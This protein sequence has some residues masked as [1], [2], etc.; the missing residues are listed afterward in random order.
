MTAEMKV[1]NLSYNSILQSFVE[2][3]NMKSIKKLQM[4][5]SPTTLVRGGAGVGQFPTFGSLNLAGFVS[6][7]SELIPLTYE[8][9][10]LLYL[11]N[12]T[13]A[14]NA[15]LGELLLDVS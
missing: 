11:L 5:Y 6:L 10:L 15:G 3:R 4:V 14:L 2:K 12:S 13:R 9:D 8:Q 7:R 1:R